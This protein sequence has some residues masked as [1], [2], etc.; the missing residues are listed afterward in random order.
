MW[1]TA[2]HRTL[3]H[4]VGYLNDDHT[5]VLMPVSLQAGEMTVT[6]G[7][8]WVAAG[9]A[10]LRIDKSQTVRALVVSPN[11]SVDAIAAGFDGVIWFLTSRSV[12]RLDPAT[13]SVRNYELP[14]SL[15]YPS[16]LTI[17]VDD[18]IWFVSRRSVGHMT[19]DGVFSEYRDDALFLSLG[20]AELY[21]AYS[22]VVMAPDGSIWAIATTGPF[23]TSTPKGSFVVR[24]LPSGGVEKI[25]DRQWVAYDIFAKD[26]SVWIADCAC[27]PYTL[28]VSR[29]RQYSVDAT[30]SREI[31]VPRTG[32]FP[33]KVINH[34]V[35]SA[36][37]TFWLTYKDEPFIT[38]LLLQ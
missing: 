26:V 32:H 38:N 11:T 3:G 2:E 20:L 14:P 6:A 17:G 13:E 21:Y 12:G 9:H 23:F 8:A 25:I 37:G 34:V 18:S 10:I 35:P 31:Y 7:A 33:E 16:R 1:F 27:A 30:L 24:V 5:P 28:E 22:Y 4:V 19:R 15:T 36:D 29:L